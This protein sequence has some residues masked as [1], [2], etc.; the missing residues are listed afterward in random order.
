MEQIPVPENETE[1]S[2]GSMK[3]MHEDRHYTPLSVDVVLP[4]SLPRHISQGDDMSHN[5]N[6]PHY[7]K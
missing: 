7:T 3:S 5:H 4:P 2:V 1:R 6:H